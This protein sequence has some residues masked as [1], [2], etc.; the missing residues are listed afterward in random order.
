MARIRRPDGRYCDVVPCPGDAFGF[1]WSGA[2]H[3]VAELD[4]RELWRTAIADS[5]LLY[6]RAAASPRAALGAV[7]QGQER[8]GCLFV[9][10]GGELLLGP[11][12]GQ[13]VAVIA[14]REDL[15]AFE[16][17]WV[18][19]VR[20]YARALVSEVGRE[21]RAL[22]RHPLPDRLAGTS[23]GLRDAAPD[24]ALLWG[25][26]QAP[27]LLAGGRRLTRW[28]ARAFVV[29]GEKNEDGEGA[30][31]AWSS[32]LRYVTVFDGPGVQP[33]NVAVNGDRI[34]VCAWTPRGAECATLA[35]PYPPHEP[36]ASTL[37]PPPPEDNMKAPK[38]TIV[39]YGPV[40]L[41]GTPWGAVIEDQENRTVTT[42]EWLP[43][44]GG[45]DFRV[46]ITNP[47]GHD[48]SGRAR[49]VSLPDASSPAPPV[50]PST[51][52]PRRLGDALLVG[53]SLLPG[54]ALR[55]GDRR[56]ELRYQRDG[57]LVLLRRRDQLVLWASDTA[58]QVPERVTLQR[59]GNLVVIAATEVTTWASDTSGDARVL[60]QNDGNAVIYGGDGRVLWA[61]GTARPD[62]TSAPPDERLPRLVADGTFFRL[63]SGD[64]FTIV[65]ASDFSLYKRFLEGEDLAPV[66][67]QRRA[68]GYNM[69]RV[70]LLN[71]SVIEGSLLPRQYPDFYARLPEFC[72]LCARHGLYVE[73]TAFTQAMTLMP[74]PAD[75]A[76]HLADIAA[77]L[78]DTTNVLLELVN[79]ADQHD[80]MPRLDVLARPLG[81]LCSH[82]SNG[83]DAAPP[84]PTWDYEL[85]HSNGLSEWWRKVGHNAMELAD[86]S[87]VPAW[88]NENTR[89]PD[90]DDNAAHAYDAARAAALLCAGSCFHSVN[91]KSSRLWSG[92]EL[93]CAEAWAD[94]A[95]SVP[96]KFRVG[97]YLH[98]TDLEGADCLRAYER[99][100]PDG[101]GYVVR[102]RP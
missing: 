54:E 100:L 27:T 78:Q 73:F 79:E 41:P 23:Q 99:R 18:W 60:L 90:D 9:D 32:Y 43:V 76:R 51:P 87:G 7:G 72:D 4:G 94:G 52:A 64:P 69:L 74:D 70:W 12:S 6:L 44:A 71:T 88:A 13:D 14:W 63:E 101:G 50:P 21:L 49:L 98:R 5:A 84:R 56:W 53:E 10:A 39:S 3:V 97:R 35:P 19:S 48:R 59:D 65:E 15:D 8:G 61:T 20:E 34:A 24:G 28:H 80:N 38:V 62:D 85:Y 45:F 26:L 86:E 29:A 42:I 57:N 92:R 1:L 67:E 2:H 36:R 77:A 102:I 46:G 33:P 16:V 68:V 17:T 91:G 11:S 93:E 66:L 81:I 37:P 40:L 25:D 22:A 83:A 30:A 58:G 75:Q 95:R 55:S 82:G 47:A 96:L 89:F 31:L